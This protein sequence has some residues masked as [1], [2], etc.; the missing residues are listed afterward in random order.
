MYNIETT[1]IYKFNDQIGILSAI[2]GFLSM[3]LESGDT[4]AKERA[5]ALYQETY[6]ESLEGLSVEEMIVKVDEKFAQ[7]GE[8]FEFLPGMLHK[9]H[10]IE[11][12]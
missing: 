5:L 7:S 3:F 9:L 11:A 4:D 12:A 8:G 6:N 10:D 2:Y 1:P